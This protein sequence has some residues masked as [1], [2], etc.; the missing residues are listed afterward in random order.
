MRI[1]PALAVAAIL[2][3]IAAA[4]T[5]SAG[6]LTIG[7]IWTR[8]TP[9]GAS[10]A[11]GY[12]RITNAGSNPDRLLRVEFASATESSLH[13]SAEAEGFSMRMVDSVPISAH[14]TPG[15]AAERIARDVH[16]SD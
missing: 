3:Q 14:A 11:V 12:L 15:I 16:R 13:E 9:P 5:F 10:T 2:A 1:I 6:D 4:Q 7:P 8:A